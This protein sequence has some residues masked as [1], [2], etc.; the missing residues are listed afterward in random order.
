MNTWTFWSGILAFCTPSSQ[1]SL[2]YTHSPPLA[3]QAVCAPLTTY[4]L[5]AVDNYCTDCGTSLGDI[6]SEPLGF[7]GTGPLDCAQ[8]CLE[9][10]P[11]NK[12]F[13]ITK[14]GNASPEV[15]IRRSCLAS[16]CRRRA[17]VNR[18]SSNATPLTPPLSPD[19]L[20]KVLVRHYPRR[21]CFRLLLRHILDRR[22]AWS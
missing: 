14:E 4:D 13:D 10:N 9:N 19:T 22:G 20:H 16:G 8:A 12:Y 5:C 18:Q 1:A 6:T 11:D 3:V 21:L 2:F 15:R 17:I 7:W